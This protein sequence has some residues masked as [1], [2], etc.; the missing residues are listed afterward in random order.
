[1]QAG[2]FS[3]TAILS[4]FLFATHHGKRS[5]NILIYAKM[6]SSM[7]RHSLSI[8]VSFYQDGLKMFYILHFT[9]RLLL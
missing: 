6:I 9:C 4:R 2:V 8:N 1:L 7:I 3:A 5:Q